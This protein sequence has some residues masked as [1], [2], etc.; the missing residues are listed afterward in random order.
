[1]STCLFLWFLRNYLEFLVGPCALGSSVIDH[2]QVYNG[3]NLPKKK[4]TRLQSS[5]KVIRDTTC[6]NHLFEHLQGYKRYN[7]WK[8]PLRSSSRLLYKRYNL[9]RRKNFF[10]SLRRHDHGRANRMANEKFVMLM[11]KTKKTKGPRWWKGIDW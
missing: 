11:W 5:S 8:S 6:E 4:D 9:Q 3:F 7:L 10:K 1:M 2:L